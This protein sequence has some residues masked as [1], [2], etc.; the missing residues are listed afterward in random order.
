MAP[1]R[2]PLAARY[3][4]ED[5]IGRGG[6]STVYR[7]T[8]S[9]LGRTVAVKVLLA[10][11]ADEDAAYVARFEREARAAAALRNPAVVAVYDVGV[12][13]E[14]RFIVME[15]VS[16]RSLAA[17][18]SGGRPLGVQDAERI[19]EQVAGALGAAHE[20]GIVHR[21]IK[22]AN[23]MLT[24]DGKVKVLDF[25]V[26]RM[27]DG[28]TITQEASVLGTAAYMAPERALGAPGDARSDIYSLGCL[29]YAMLAGAPPFR[30]EHAA[31]LL[32]QHVNA[33][34]RHVREL[35]AGVPATLDALVDR[36]L[37]KSPAARP[38]SAYEVRDHL[39]AASDPTAPTVTLAPIAPHPRRR[40]ALV[41]ALAL[42][43]GGLIVVAIASGGGSPRQASSTAG[44]TSSPE[45]APPTTRSAPTTSSASS[46]SSTPTVT[47]PPQ[48][49]P[50]A[51][52]PPGH[53]KAPPGHEKHHGKG[54]GKEH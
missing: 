45:A 29:M 8:D 18:L 25:G 40:R 17:L 11:L 23:V 22:P 19:G 14:V 42:A 9:K 2:S 43:A 36:M 31:A 37:A 16:G 7:A 20:R 51:A 27:L 28:T 6:M 30:G 32:H 4:L 21:D 39:A 35:R 49:A 44:T 5:V 13:G 26:A 24:D 33:A 53:G 50:S 52:G 1:A 15:H 48:P 12:D 47:T 54:K 3:R 38:R 34:P 10:G 41:A 46:I